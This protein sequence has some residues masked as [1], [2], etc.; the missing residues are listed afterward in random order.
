[1]II[2]GEGANNNGMLYPYI[3]DVLARRF[4]AIVVQPEH[5]FYGPYPPVPYDSVTSET[6]LDVFTPEQAM[7]DM[8]RLV[9]VHLR[10]GGNVLYG[11]SSD[12]T[13]TNYCPLI[14]I[15]ASY[16][17][18]LSSLFRIV[19][20]DVV[21]AAY[22]SSAPLLMYAQISDNAK[23]YDIV[24]DAADITSPGCANSVRDTLSDVERMIME[25]R[26]ADEAAHK[27]GVCGG[28]MLPKPL[29]HKRDLVDALNLMAVYGFANYDM[30]NYPPGYDTSMYR[31]CRVFQDPELDSVSTMKAYLR[32]QLLEQWED[33]NGCDMA[34]VHCTD[35]MRAAY[36]LETYGGRDCF[37]M[38]PELDD[39]VPD[40]YEE[41]Y[42]GRKYDDMNMW[43]FQTC[44]NVIFLAGQSRYSMFL[45]SEATYRDLERD[46]VDMFGHDVVPRP[47]ELNDRWHFAPAHDLVN[48]ANASRILFTNGLQDMWSGGSYL[49]TL[50]ASLPVINFE[51]GAHHSDLTHT[52]VEY[53][54]IHDTDEIRAGKV[55]IADILGSWIEE[56][57]EGMVN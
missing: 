53:D 17:G 6:L 24:T 25:S 3:T 41:V 45:E 55:R 37:D 40:G 8:I 23:Y 52:S 18:F 46:C 54:E 57:R 7:Y 48:V 56:I 15:G 9:T 11:C 31:I 35:E 26:T 2:G 27:V 49:E 43:N 14:T 28:D 47:T 38:R 19:H 51:M 22:A 30:G 16:P 34:T 5:R 1:M 12:R 4:D 29:R 20:P 10:E 36:L 42:D 33:D 39:D 21:D 32:E 50:S 44:T 13:S